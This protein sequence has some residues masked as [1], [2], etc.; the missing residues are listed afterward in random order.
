MSD[1]PNQVNTLQAPAVE[2][3]FATANPRAS[4]LAGEG[5]LIAGRGVIDGVVVPGIVVGRFGWTTYES[6]DNDNAPGTVNTFGSGQPA[7]LVHRAQVGFILPFLATASMLL[8][9]GQQT[10]LFNKVDLWVKNRGATAAQ[11]G[12]KAFAVF[13]DGSA[14]FAATGATPGGGSGSA[15]SIAAATFAATGSIAGDTATLTAIGSGTVYAGATISGSGV[16]SGTKIVSQL[17]PLLTGEAI[18]GVGR[19]QVSIPEQSVASTAISGTYGVLTVGGT[20]VNGFGP[21]QTVTGSGISAPTTVYQQLTGT[22]GGAGTYVVDVN[23]VVSS[24]A[25]TSANAIETKWIA[26]SAGAVG[27]LVKISDIP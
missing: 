12:Q 14:S 13:A 25:I 20:V 15:S 2:G 26:R 19:Y 8:P 4:V 10:M 1:F 11:I 24:T 16:A 6:V 18:G 5:A 23:T 7:G 22:A 17:T 21:G 27:E 3:D 9:T